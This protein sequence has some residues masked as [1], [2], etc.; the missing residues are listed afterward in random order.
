MVE[1]MKMQNVI[2]AERDAVVGSVHV[3]E[4]DEVAVDEELVTFEAK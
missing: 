1:A 4:G 2:R 3:E